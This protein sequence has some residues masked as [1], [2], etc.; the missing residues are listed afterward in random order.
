MGVWVLWCVEWWVYS[1]M[2]FIVITGWVVG[3]FALLLDFGLFGWVLVL[4]GL[5]FG[6]VDWFL[7]CYWLLYTI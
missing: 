2:L 6:L 3:L 5:G 1:T 4:I 7:F